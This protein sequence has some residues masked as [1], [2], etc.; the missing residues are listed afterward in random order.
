MGK[1]ILAAGIG[2]DKAEPFRIVEPFDCTC[3]HVYCSCE[4]RMTGVR[5]VAGTSRDRDEDLRNAA[6]AAT[7][8][9]HFHLTNLQPTHTPMLQ[10]TQCIS[11]KRQPHDL[12]V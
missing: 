9:Q 5:P 6:K 2:R 4:I 7:T 8:D 10:A 11:A 3:T 12:S 1:E